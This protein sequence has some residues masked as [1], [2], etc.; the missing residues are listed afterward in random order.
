MSIIFTL[1][2]SNL[3]RLILVPPEKR[4][5]EIIFSEVLRKIKP[6]DFGE[7]L[8]LVPTHRKV[9]EALKTFAEYMRKKGEVKYFF[10]PQILTLSDFAQKKSRLPFQKRVSDGEREVLLSFLLRKLSQDKVGVSRAAA[11]FI[12][13]SKSYLPHLSFEE[14]EILIRNKLEEVGGRQ[15]LDVNFPS[16]LMRRLDLVFEVSRSYEKIFKEKNLY[17]QED[18]LQL[19]LKKKGKISFLAISGF[20]DITEL[21]WR[22]LKHLLSR[23]ENSWVSVPFFSEEVLSSGFISRLEESFKIEK[24]VIKKSGEKKIFLERFSSRESEVKE[25]AR[26]ILSLKEERVTFHQILVTF[27]S[28]ES[29]ASFIERIFSSYGIPFNLSCGKPLKQSPPV[30]DILFLLRSISENFPRNIFSQVLSSPFFSLVPEELKGKLEMITCEAQ[31]VKG[32]E[33]WKE[34][35]KLL[36]KISPSLRKEAKDLSYFLKETFKLIKPFKKRGNFRT[37]NERLNSFLRKKGFFD[38][39]KSRGSEDDLKAWESFRRL[40]FYLEKMDEIFGLQPHSLSFEDYYRVLKASV[41]RSSYWVSG[42]E[43][44]VQ[45]LGLLESRGLFF[46]YIFFGGLVDEE[47]PGKVIKDVFLPEA[48]KEEIGFP[49]YQKRFSLM[50]MSFERLLS[51]GKW[52]YLSYPQKEGE[53]TFLPTRFLQEVQLEEGWRKKNKIFS[54]LEWQRSAKKSREL[55]KK[56]LHKFPEALLL[57]KD[58]E[59]TFKFNVEK[60]DFFVTSIETFLSCPFRF[61]LRDILSFEP[62]KEPLY[63]REPLEWGKGVHQILERIFSQEELNSEVDPEKIKEVFLLEAQKIFGWNGR[64]KDL[65]EWARLSN[66]AHKLAFLESQRRRRGISI[67]DTEKKTSLKRGDFVFKGRID[68][69]DML[70]EGGVEILDYKTGGKPSSFLQLSVYTLSLKEQGEEVKNASYLI[71]LENDCLYHP[72]EG[73]RR[74]LE[75][76]LEKTEEEI[77]RFIEGVRSGNFS[78]RREGNTCFNCDYLSLCQVMECE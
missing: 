12:K 60:R 17:D 9:R 58:I 74:K 31:I 14:L 16:R 15:S 46:P 65:V 34:G 5:E 59:E 32:E 28:L 23:A 33:E 56:L 52:I 3:L 45:V 57:K 10:P 77:E 49:S 26:K 7:F 39:L 75:R 78:P 1:G 43:D 48:V 6:P 40:L 61:L 47:F 68:R 37:F 63:E 35:L 42:R 71:L 27:P 30:R 25:I 24:K 19:I 20:Y 64:K 2:E 18:E 44:G 67:L 66:V 53:V 76:I 72:I 69:I 22:L 36:E 54:L 62:L 29:Y 41:L 11:D 51:S 13:M 73:K 4:E 55:L 50:R 21:E 70:P 38:F 8:Y